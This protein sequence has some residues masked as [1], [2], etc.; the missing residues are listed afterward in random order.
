MRIDPNFGF[1]VPI[2]VPGVDQL[3][4]DPRATWADKDAYDAKA[5]HLV[6]LFI[7]NFAQFEDHVDAGVREA[8]PKAA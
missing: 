7:A 5:K 2:A 1:Q 4:L 3:I 6:E 8:A